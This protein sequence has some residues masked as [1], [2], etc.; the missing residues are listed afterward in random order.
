MDDKRHIEI[1]ETTRVVVW[2]AWIAGKLFCIGYL[3][4]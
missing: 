1:M 3:L 2:C 4:R